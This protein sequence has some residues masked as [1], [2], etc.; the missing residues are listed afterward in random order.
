MYKLL[1][2]IFLLMPNISWATFGQNEFGDSSGGGGGGSGTVT[3]V[4]VSSG[5]GFSGTVATATT[6]PAITLSTTV[7]GIAK[8]NGTDLSAATDGTDYLSPSGVAT[9]TNKTIVGSSNTISGITESM[10]SLS[11]LTTLDVSITKHGF[12]PRAP[13]D[14]TKFLDGTG[15]WT[16]PAAAGGGDV[17]A[18]GNCLTG[19]CFNGTSGDTLTF[20][21][22]GGNATIVY[23]GTDFAFS[24]TLRVAS[25]NTPQTDYYP[26]LATDTHWIIGVN[27]DGGNDN[28]D[29]LVISEGTT[30][31]SSNRLTIAP[32]GLVTI[33]SATIT[34]ITGHTTIENVT[35]TGATGSGNFVFSISPTI[36]GHA[37]IEGVTATGAT[38]T[39]NMVYSTSPT[40]V[41]P[42]L[43]VAT[44]TSINLSSV[45]SSSDTLVNRNTSETLANKRLS[46]RNST[47][48]SSATPSIN[49]DGTDIFTIT[50]QAAAITS[51]T[52]GLS[53]TPVTGQKLIIRIKDNG[54]ARAITWGAS[55]EAMGVA[56]PTTTVVSK[57]MYVLFIYN[58][59]AA[60]W[61][62]MAVNQET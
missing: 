3:S 45:T 14:A 42:V 22:A 20:Y 33:P 28:D 4:S 40:L 18:V 13:N 31:G 26:T 1:I 43:G 17:T 10:L 9:V 58:A 54:T 44:A 19:A 36:T 32:G 24:K 23:D 15:A 48:G 60:K 8:G 37:T 51:M 6:T 25:S 62:C 39:G 7:S 27:G 61:D 57:T 30:L 53:G 12:A 11:D 41:T 56:L 47:I 50:S 49:T 46:P 29:N 52:T 2:L 5:N 34:T 21:N 59:T 38:G 55:Y 35:P 16:A